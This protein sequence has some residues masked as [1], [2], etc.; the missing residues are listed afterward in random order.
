MRRRKVDVPVM[1]ELSMNVTAA[2]VVKGKRVLVIGASG[3]VG[4]HLLRQLFAEG[5]YHVF[6]TKLPGE[7]IDLPE[8][9]DAGLSVL[10][11]NILSAEDTEAVISSV[12]PDVIMHLAAQSSVGLSF[13]KPELTM[14]INIIGSLHVLDAVRGACPVARLLFIGSSEQYGIVRED[15]LPVQEYMAAEPVSPY[16]VSKLAVE[17]LSRVYVK[18]YGLDILLVRAFN[19]IGPGQLPAFVVSDFARQIAL[20]EKKQNEAILYVGDLSAKRDFT[21]VRDIV[22]GYIALTERGVSGEIYNI[23]SG[24]SLSVREILDT[25]L[26]ASKAGIAVEV[27]PERIRPIEIPEIRADISKI[28]RDTGWKPQISIMKSLED[29]LDY[30]RANV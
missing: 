6:A 11:L 14:K 1:S 7:K 12:T 29:T 13:Q 26:S 3:F 28:Q 8:L 22:R 24:V 30:W 16:A 5:Y 15:M 17:Q 20:I 21:D 18:S 23:G 25:L 4:H 9:H 2:E 27:T 10:D 19:H